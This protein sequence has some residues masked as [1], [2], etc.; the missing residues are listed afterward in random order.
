MKCTT[1]VDWLKC[2]KA[3][4]VRL[5]ETHAPSHESIRKWF[6]NSG[7]CVVSSCCSNKS[8]GTAILV[9]DTY[10][11]TKAIKDDAGRFIQTIVDFGE[12]ELSFISLYAPNKNPE[13]N[14]FSPLT[15]LI[16]LSRP[17][18]VAGDSSQFCT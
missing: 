4:V 9:K 3:D 14:T 15:H 5:Q 1:L 6:A 8:G 2:M 13:R 17:V 12:D 18:F 16:D 7:Y 11:I 10:K